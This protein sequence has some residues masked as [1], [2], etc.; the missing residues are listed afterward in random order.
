MKLVGLSQTKV[1]GD[2]IE[3][4]VRHTLQF[5]D[6]LI[7]VDNTSVDTTPSILASLIAEGLPVTVWPLGP[8]DSIVGDPGDT[9]LARRAF[10]ERAPDYLLILDVDEFIRAE[11]REQLEASLRALPAGAHAMV[12]RVNYLPTPEDDDSEV[13]ALARIRHRLRHENFPPKI[14]LNASFAASPAAEL[15]LGNHDVE[16]PTGLSVVAPLAAIDLAHFPVRGLAQTRAKALL[17]WSIYIA[18][19]DEHTGAGHR[20]KELYERLLNSPQASK[21]ELLRCSLVY[22]DLD[23]EVVLDPLPPVACRYP[24]AT[25]DLLTIALAFTRQLAEAYAAVYWRNSE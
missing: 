17:G 16:D 19:G 7:I 25:H 14:F 13:R 20:W 12:P 22:S 11:S 21:D 6:E 4:F 9:A 2:I 8:A 5:V 18:N 1:E 3:E 24:P 10:A 23:G 15:S